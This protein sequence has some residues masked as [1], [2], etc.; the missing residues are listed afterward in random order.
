MPTLNSN[1]HR[2]LASSPLCI[3]F[4]PLLYHFPLPESLLLFYILY[5]YEKLLILIW[6]QFLYCWIQWINVWFVMYTYLIETVPLTG[7]VILTVYFSLTLYFVLLWGEL[8][9]SILLYLFLV[10]NKNVLNKKKSF[11][12]LWVTHMKTTD[13]L[14]CTHAGPNHSPVTWKQS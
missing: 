12:K 10:C 6:L 9:C 14:C 3:F 11:G 8:Y 2:F 4:Y 1:N 13:T 7:I 5:K